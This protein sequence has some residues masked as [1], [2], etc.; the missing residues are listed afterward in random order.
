MSRDWENSRYFLREPANSS[1][2]AAWSIFELAGQPEV[3]LGYRL[4][5][6]Y[7]GQGYAAEAAAAIL[8]YGFDA[9]SRK[10]I[11]AFALPQNRTSLKILEKV[12]FEYLN[13]FIHA[14]LPHKL[15]EFPR[16]KF[17]A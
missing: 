9:L 7:W 13:D 4:C 15:Y 5:L 2:P 17:I 11:L 16:E 14:E 12:G 1:A 3:E 6:K 8:K 10:R